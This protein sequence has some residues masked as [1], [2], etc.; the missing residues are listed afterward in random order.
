M[1]R[2]RCKFGLNCRLVMPVTLVPT[3]PRYFAL[4]RIVTVLPTAGPLPQT[5]HERAIAALPKPPVANAAE[6]GNR[7]YIGR[8]DFTQPKVAARH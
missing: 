4:P 8:A 1:T 7:Q 2:T 3:P 6:T 5:S